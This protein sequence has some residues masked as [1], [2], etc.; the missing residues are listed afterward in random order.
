M[1]LWVRSKYSILNPNNLSVLRG[2]IGFSLP[3]LILTPGKLCHLWAFVL[4]LFGAITDYWDGELARRY[5]LESAFGK[6]VDPFTD[7]ILILAPLVAFASLGL[8]SIWWIVPIFFREVV[9]TFCRTGWLL[10]GKSFGAEKLGKLK[11]VF[12]TASVWLAFAVVIFWDYFATQT[13]G[14]VLNSFLNPVLAVTVALTLVSGFFFLWNQRA[15][16]S[17]QYFIKYV[18]ATGVGL[19]PKAPGTWGSLL[20]VLLVFLTGWNIFLY[21]AVLISLV[22]AGDLAFRSLAD[23][24]DKDPHYVVIDEVIGIFV[25]FLLIPLS[26]PSMIL[27]FILFRLFD[28]WKPFPVRLFEQIPG[29]WGIVADD[30]AAGIYAWIVLFLIFC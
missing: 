13:F 20:G 25:T 22:T 3:F 6:W 16:F 29:Y 5:K 15:H 9:V 10:E 1:T 21:A 12:Q 23:K 11:F 17:S 19:L 27:G 8:F 2:V 4:F 14:K 28:V 7:K 30:I 24:S 18:L 26:W